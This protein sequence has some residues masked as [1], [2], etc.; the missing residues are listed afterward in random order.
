[1]EPSVKL[2]Y[3]GIDGEPGSSYHWVGKKTG[4]GTMSNTGVENGQMNYGLHFVKPFEGDADG[5]L[6]VEDSAGM[7][8]VTWT[9]HSVNDNF[10]W[11]GI[12]QVMSM[13]HS[14][15]DDFTDGLNNMKQYVESHKMEAPAAPASYAIQEA[16]FPGN[17][18]AG[19]RKTVKWDEMEKTMPGMY[20]SAAKAAGE[21][22]SGP[23]IAIYYKWD[24]AK[25]EA[26]VYAGFPVKE[27][28]AVDGA[29]MVKVPA[30]KAYLV[31]FTGNYDQ[32]EKIHYQIGSHADAN[33][34]NV[35]YVLEEYLKMAPEEKDPNKWV[36]NVYCISK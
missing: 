18:Y 13:F 36:T 27:D 35:G 11:A 14:L 32:L 16:Q 4:E 31:N 1:A 2:T 7:S 30:A 24:T 22:I 12:G 29:T 19:I 28:K 34:M 8:K 23:P 25:H 5:Y 17:M 26:D 33:K 15:E 21:R 20:E 10:L 9:F 6:K 3:S